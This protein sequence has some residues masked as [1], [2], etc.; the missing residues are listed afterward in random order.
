MIYDDDPI[1]DDWLKECGFRWSQE[2][3]QPSKHWT[4]WLG[5]PGAFAAAEDIGIE[6]AAVGHDAEWFCWMR[7]DF[8]H[9]YS[10]FI[11]IRHLTMRG[12]VVALVTAISGQAWDVSRHRYG[13]VCT[14]A[15]IE[16]FDRQDARLRRRLERTGPTEGIDVPWPPRSVAAQPSQDPA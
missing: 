6:L 15:Q 12:E 16:A 2:E 11:H 8:S 7:S 13:R 10:R 14:P 3:R 9:R 5:M 1:T 4:L